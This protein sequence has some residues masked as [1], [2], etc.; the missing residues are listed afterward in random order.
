[1]K[2]LVKLLFV[3]LPTFLTAQSAIDVKAPIASAKDR[4]KSFK[5]ATL[6]F[7]HSAR[8]ATVTGKEIAA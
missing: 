1:M 2:T 7:D 3:L 4:Q 8:R 6:V 5:P